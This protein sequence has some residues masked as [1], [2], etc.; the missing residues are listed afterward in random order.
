MTAPATQP[1]ESDLW[2]DR[3]GDGEE[4]AGHTIHTHYFGFNIPEEKLGCFIY[5]RAMP[6][7]NITSGGVCI[8]RGVDN[9]KNIDIDHCNFFYTMPFPKVE[10]G[11]VIKT[12]NG[13]KVTFLE[14]G[15][16]AR[17]EYESK[18]G[19]TKFDVTQVAI[20]PLLPRGHVMPGEEV[21]TNPKQKPGGSEQYMKCTG[22]LTLN[23]KDLKVDCFS[24]RDRSWRQVR[25]EE[26]VEYPPVAWSPI[27]FGEDLVFNQCGY[28]STQVWK[29]QFRVDPEKPIHFFSWLYKNGEIRQ[30]PKVKRTILRWDPKT[31]S[32]SEQIIEA[33]DD[34]GQKY[35]F[36]GEAIA[37]AHLPSWPNG[38]FIDLV[39]KWTDKAS[40]R[41]TYCTY[42]EAWY[43]KNQ[44]F[45]RGKIS[46][47]GNFV[48]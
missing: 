29:D 44:H 20:T 7:F 31:Y 41:V 25:T 37:A 2:F 34:H 33:E 30:I 10:E 19:K 28:D 46:P 38:V 15:R 5:I 8:F 35:E 23:G 22:S 21:N 45:M 26:E 17:I 12:A 4:W 40:G 27:C 3:P 48:G 13:L 42:Q 14:P 18:D 1:L 16:K 36:H 43:A 6:V 39:Y 47:D 32:A 9:V 11:N 24:V